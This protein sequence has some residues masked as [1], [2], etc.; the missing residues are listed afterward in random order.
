MSTQS[1]INE[2]RQNG[3]IV[4]INHVR[5]FEFVAADTIN[6]LD[7]MLTRG[8]FSRAISDG[9]LRY[10]DRDDDGYYVND[11]IAEN[12]ELVFGQQVS[13]KGGFTTVVI[14][15]DGQTLARGKY[16]FNGAPFVKRIGLSAA[17]GRAIKQIKS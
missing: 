15:K 3:Y 2:L 5:A 10:V 16:N 1:R 4:R 8:E 14:E 12:E 9:K 13:P 7:N 17:F 6:G 11:Y